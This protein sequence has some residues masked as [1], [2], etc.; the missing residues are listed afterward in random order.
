[1]VKI[2]GLMDKTT[3]QYDA[4]RTEKDDNTTIDN[5]TVKSSEGKLSS[6]ASDYLNELRKQYNDYDFV[7]ADAGDDY[8]G[9]VK[10]SSK[11]YTVVW[12]STDL[13]RMT[14][15]KKFAAEKINSVKSIVSYT[16]ERICKECVFESAYGKHQNN[17]SQLKNIAVSSDDNGILVLFAG[18]EKITK[19]RNPYQKNNE[20]RYI[21]E[22]GV[23]GSTTDE[24][25]EK[26]KSI[27]WA[28][29]SGRIAGNG[30]NV[31]F[32]A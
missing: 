5:T 22:K 17:D 7:I 9:L 16:K 20:E 11:E 29:L 31:D 10:Q 6:K 26:I 14:Y 12:S 13:E 32:H 21:K 8:K 30:D 24:L 18:L 4:V 15:D 25:L 2:N 3:Y 28:S 1:M 23:S 27:D 19:K